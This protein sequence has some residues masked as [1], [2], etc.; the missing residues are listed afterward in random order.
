MSKNGLQMRLKLF[1]FFAVFLFAATSA[2]AKR[3]VIT[4]NVMTAN[5]VSHKQVAKAMKDEPGISRVKFNRKAGTADVTFDDTQTTLRAVVEA[6]RKHGFVAFP[7]GENCS[8]KRGGCLNNP[9]TQMNTL[10]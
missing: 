6:F 8:R 10:Q 4:F 2:D 1:I 7:I 9:P 5:T 3:R